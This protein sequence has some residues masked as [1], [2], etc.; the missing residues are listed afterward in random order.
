MFAVADCGDLV[1]TDTATAQIEGG[2]MF[3][4]SAAL[5]GEITIA[6]GKVVESNFHDFR[7][8]TLVDAPRVHVDFVMSGAH[9]GGLG[10]PAV[11]PIAAAV[12][13]AIF[14][15]TGVRVRELPFSRAKLAATS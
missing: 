8:M 11:P 14:A 4:L 15:A 1:N 5:L 3:G 13:N 12:A 9:P 2:V 7:T 10:E 6:A